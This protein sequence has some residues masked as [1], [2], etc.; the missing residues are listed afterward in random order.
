MQ[1]VFTHITYEVL[2]W[3]FDVGTQRQDFILIHSSFSSEVDYELSN[4]DKWEEKV[5]M[6]QSAHLLWHNAS[7]LAKSPYRWLSRYGH[8]GDFTL[9][10]LLVL[11]SYETLFKCVSVSG[12]LGAP[13]GEKKALQLVV[14]AYVKCWILWVKQDMQWKKMLMVDGFYSLGIG[15]IVK[16]GI[17]MMTL[18]GRGLLT[19]AAQVITFWWKK[20]IFL[21]N[22]VN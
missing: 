22:K 9:T 16:S 21:E 11:R 13:L 15:W 12:P 2:C 17:Y 7:S 18:D 4:H 20:H 14:I 8:V 5:K 6:L 10:I 3:G 19:W 1:E